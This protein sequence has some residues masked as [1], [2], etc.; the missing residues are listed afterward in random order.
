[1]KNNNKIPSFTLV[2]ITVTMLI[3]ATVI[4]MAMWIFLNINQYYKKKI[5]EN[6]FYND[7]LD[8]QQLLKSDMAKSGVVE[9]SDNELICKSINREYRYYFNEKNVIREVDISSDTFYLEVKDIKTEKLGEGPV[10]RVNLL[11]SS[12]EL[13]IPVSVIKEYPRDVLFENAIKEIDF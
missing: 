10:K 3:T 13:N 8:L 7:L 6:A 2:E 5:D 9:Y 12:G 1:M 4:S 11:I